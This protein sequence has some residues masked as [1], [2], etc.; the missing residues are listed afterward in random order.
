MLSYASLYVDFLFGIAIDFSI[1][2]NTYSDKLY[3]FCRLWSYNGGGLYEEKSFFDF[4][5]DIFDS[6]R[7]YVFIRLSRTETNQAVH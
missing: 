1:C 5:Y 4:F 6:V 2:Y 7:K 3:V